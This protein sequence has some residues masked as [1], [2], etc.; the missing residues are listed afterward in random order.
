MYP[1]VNSLTGVL[2]VLVRAA[3]NDLSARAAAVVEGR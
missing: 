3:T 2:A 1:H